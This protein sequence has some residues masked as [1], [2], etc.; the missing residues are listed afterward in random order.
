MRLTWGSEPRLGAG[1][2]MATL[3][4]MLNGLFAAAY[5]LDPNSTSSIKSIAKDIAAD[6][7]SMYH[8]HEPGG[9]PGLLPEPYYCASFLQLLC[10]GANRLSQGG[11]P[12]P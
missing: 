9:T 12:V 8:G 5:E 2:L 4:M 6:L 1:A 10:P 7:V 3:L 11:I